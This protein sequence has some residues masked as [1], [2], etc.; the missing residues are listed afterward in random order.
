MPCVR[1]AGTF[2]WGPSESGGGRGEG[3]GQR[4]PAFGFEARSWRERA[5]QI[6]RKLD[7]DWTLWC[8]NG[9]N[10]GPTRPRVRPY[11]RLNS[12]APRSALHTYSAPGSALRRRCRPAPPAAWRCPRR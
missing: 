4:L 7:S 11:T 8:A 10:K 5:P 2:E 3:G 1:S 12:R 6:G 9:A